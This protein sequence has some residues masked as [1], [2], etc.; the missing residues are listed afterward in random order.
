MIGKW[1]TIGTLAAMTVAVTAGVAWLVSWIFK[2]DFS[3][4]LVFAF[5]YDVALASQQKIWESDHQ[6]PRRL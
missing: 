5:G 2:L 1:L 4:V 3:T 6:T